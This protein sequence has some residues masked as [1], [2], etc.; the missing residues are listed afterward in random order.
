MRGLWY[1]SL[2]LGCFLGEGMGADGVTRSAQG[3]GLL[4]LRTALPCTPSLGGA[5]R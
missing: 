1:F 5:Q 2:L 3:L 4:P